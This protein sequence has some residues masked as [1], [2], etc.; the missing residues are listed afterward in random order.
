ML[1]FGACRAAYLCCFN[2]L[3]ELP[4]IP[5][6]LPVYWVA[7]L[8]VGLAV[9]C[10]AARMSGR[11]LSPRRGGLVS[12]AAVA[13]VVGI[14]LLVGA[15]SAGGS[16]PIV[17]ALGYMGAVLAG[18]GCACVHIL[19]GLKLARLPERSVIAYVA[20]G[21]TTA[22]VAL[23]AINLPGAS[24]G[25]AALA[26]TLV[27][28]F[29]LNDG[30]VLEE[31][32]E[33]RACGLDDPR[34]HRA[35][36]AFPEGLAASRGMCAKLCAMMFV[37]PFAYHFAVMTFI[38]T[39]VMNRDVEGLVVAVLALIIVLVARRVRLLA[40]F[41]CVLPVVV[42]A[43]LFMQLLPPGV[44]DACAVVAGSGLKLSELFVWALL[45]C[46]ARGGLRR[47]WVLAG[48]GTAAMFAGRAAAFV[49]AALLGG[50][51]WYSP[52]VAAY[53][54]VVVLVVAVILML[55]EGWPHAG[56]DLAGAVGAA[57]ASVAGIAAGVSP[58]PAPALAMRCGLLA[59]RGGLTRRE[60]EILVLLAS[61]RSQ[62]II[63]DRLDITEGTAHVHIVHIYRKLGVHGQQELITLVESEPDVAR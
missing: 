59:E 61:G 62:S 34:P 40:I 6:A 11:D 37:I 45:V 13:S 47:R 55:P 8:A 3:N 31:G 52:A 5:F 39:T 2:A 43:Y 29:T 26:L 60:S 1:G 16:S 22:A 50:L 21:F 28:L 46:A 27:A 19:W 54:L 14:L 15:G 63:A 35:E 48:L 9:A 58:Q 20:L 17:S 53:L 7:A 51:P 41:K 44:L 38:Q 36:A 18:A 33:G 30:W 4:T 49:C 42:A 25:Y 23:L 57:P 56:G 24:P 12:L 10:A 32:G